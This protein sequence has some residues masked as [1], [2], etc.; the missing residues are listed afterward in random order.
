MLGVKLNNN[1]WTIN[2]LQNPNA[3]RLT[4]GLNQT[5]SET[6]DN[7]IECVIKSCNQILKNV[8]P[9]SNLEEKFLVKTVFYKIFKNSNKKKVFFIMFLTCF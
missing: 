3:L 6:I 8:D 5:H 1:G 9:N 4:I 7:F 2:F